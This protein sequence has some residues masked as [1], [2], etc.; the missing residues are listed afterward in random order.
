[1]HTGEV[2]GDPKLWA[3]FEEE[4]LR[5]AGDRQAGRAK[6]TRLGVPVPVDSFIQE[7]GRGCGREAGSE[8]MQ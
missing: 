5:I 3:R 8:Q 6:R 4:R 7:G 1:M 2:L